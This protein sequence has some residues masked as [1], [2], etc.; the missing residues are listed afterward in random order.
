MENPDTNRT[1]QGMNGGEPD[2]KPDMK[3]ADRKIAEIGRRVRR[4]NMESG[5]VE[6]V[7]GLGFVW[8][9]MFFLGRVLLGDSVAVQ[10]SIGPLR[11]FDMWPYMLAVWCFGATLPT[12]WLARRLKS[13]LVEPRAGMVV[14]RG[15]T[16]TVKRVVLIIV[17]GAIGGGVIGLLCALVPEFYPMAERG[18]ALMFGV[19]GGGIL[20][21]TGMHFQLRRFQALAAFSVVL[22]FVMFFLH[23]DDTLVT[24]GYF[25]L[26]GVA[27]IVSGGVAL[28]AF[29]RKNPLVET[30]TETP[31]GNRP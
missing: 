17:G 23:F 3:E 10:I 20:F 14:L 7:N 31:E 18:Y 11:G 28:R 4:G 27:F 15:A 6:L 9:G 5:V 29:V 21:L 13:R 25:S 30:K 8:I 26:I 24:G 16:W 12:V 1:D 19:F 2:V 22:G